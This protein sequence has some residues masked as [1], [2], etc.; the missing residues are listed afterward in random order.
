MKFSRSMKFQS[1]KHKIFVHILKKEVGSTFNQSI[2]NKYTKLAI[3][4]VELSDMT[5]ISSNKSCLQ[6]DK[7]LLTSRVS[8]QCSP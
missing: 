1:S 5:K 4:A 2:F 8:I 6:W 7:S 3:L